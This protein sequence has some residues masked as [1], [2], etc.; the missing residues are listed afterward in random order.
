MNWSNL[1][2]LDSTRLDKRLIAV[3]SNYKQVKMGT[4][5]SCEFTWASA[6]ILVF[7]KNPK[8]ITLI[9]ITQM[10]NIIVEMAQNGG[11]R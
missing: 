2:C 4:W 1:F 6:T 8:Y 11:K 10:T 3:C 5:N 7:E 9:Y